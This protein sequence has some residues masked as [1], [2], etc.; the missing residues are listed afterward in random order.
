[1]RHKEKRILV[2]LG[3]IFILLIVIIIFV[4]TN[5]LGIHKFL[6]TEITITTAIVCLVIPN[7]VFFPL[8][9]SCFFVANRASNFVY[10]HDL[11]LERRGFFFGF[12]KTISISSIQGINKITLFRDGTFYVIDDGTSN[13]QERLQKKS[14]IFIPYTEKGVEFINMFYS[15]TIPPLN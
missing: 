15:G 5:V 2:D 9:I 12:K 6:E 1:M 10:F 8:L 14:A 11:V 13:C 7:I 3:A 4:F